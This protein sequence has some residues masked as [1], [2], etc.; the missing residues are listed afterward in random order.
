M[1]AA[2]PIVWISDR[3]ARKTINVGANP[4]VALVWSGAAETYVWGEAELVDEVA[5]KRAMWADAWSYDPAMFFQ[6]PDNPDYV[7]IRVRPQALFD[8]LLQFA[9]Q[10]GPL[11]RV[12]R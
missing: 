9:R 11:N 3:S 5:V 2:R 4:S 8:D 1:R 7:L 12:Y 10:F 6:T